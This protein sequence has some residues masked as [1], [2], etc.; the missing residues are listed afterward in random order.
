MEP[1]QEH[2]KAERGRLTK[3]AKTL[4]VSPGA[5]SQWEGKVPAEHVLV[6][7][8]ETGLSRHDLRPDVFG[9]APKKRRA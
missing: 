8:R 5:V 3:L 1:L 6:V 7:E 2:L 4:G 9:P